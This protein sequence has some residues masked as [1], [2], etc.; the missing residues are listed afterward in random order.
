MG[1]EKIERKRRNR[2]WKIRK[3]MLHEGYLKLEAADKKY[4]GENSRRLITS[5]IF[6]AQGLVRYRKKLIPKVKLRIKYHKKMK[7]WRIMGGKK[8]RGKLPNGRLETNI[9]D[10]L[11]LSSRFG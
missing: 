6:R 3:N 5:Q 9:N 1:K 8:Y 4:E 11:T 7:L 2:E 10:R